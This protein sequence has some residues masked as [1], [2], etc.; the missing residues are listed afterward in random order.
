MKPN[1]FNI[2]RLLRQRKIISQKGQADY[3]LNQLGIKDVMSE[4]KKRI[5][6]E[7]L[8]YG[9]INERVDQFFKE[10]TYRVERP[11]ITYLGEDELDSMLSKMVEEAKAFYMVS[12]FPEIAYSTDLA[13]LIK[14]GSFVESLGEKIG[15]GK[16][17]VQILTTI[18]TDALFD[19][20]FRTHEDPKTAYEESTT[21]VNRLK[22]QTKKHKNL[23]VRYS[24]EP[25][26]LDIAIVE[27]VIPAQFMMFTR[28]EHNDINGGILVKSNKTS[29][30]AL[31]AFEHGFSSATNI[32]TSVGYTIL[33]QAKQ[34]LTEK[35]SV[36]KDQ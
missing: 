36:L 29:A 11:D 12:D 6:S 19:H 31:R 20:A 21:V 9:K 30:N 34:A 1:L 5:D 22:A 13:Q 28:D 8:E 27:T 7:I 4:A 32:A 15:S 17:T 18:N 2:L 33:D 14:R 16:I 10:L 24:P 35:Y 25:T 26:S 23:E 3:C